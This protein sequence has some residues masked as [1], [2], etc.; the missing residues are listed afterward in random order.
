MAR[1][2]LKDLWRASYKGAPF[3]TE[4]DQESGGRRI[5][6]HQFPMR[7]EPFL[8]DLGEDLREFDITAYLA[9]DSADAE[10][11]ALSAA[12]ASRGA[13]VLVM[14]VQGPVLVRCVSF[15]RDS[16][17]D[18]AGY[19]A[20]SLKCCRE[21]AS[22][23]LATVASLANLIFVAADNAATVVAASFAAEFTVSG[24]SGA[25]PQPVDFVVA[26]AINGLRNGVAALEAIRV[27]EPVDPVASAVQRDALQ[28]LYDT[29]PVLLETPAGITMAPLDLI[30]TTRALG[31]AMPAN[32]A[33]RAFEA[34]IVAG[35]AGA[36]AVAASYPTSNLR[37][38][39]V[40]AAATQRALR[41]AALLAYSEA[42]ARMVI[43]DRPAGITLRANVAEY[44]EAEVVDLPASEID[45]VHQ[46]GVLRGAVIDYI[47]RA[48]LDL[49][50][51]ITVE[52]NLSLPSLAL[53]W[54]LYQDP[55]R[56]IELVARNRVVHPS[57][58]PVAFE[59]LAR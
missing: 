43:P 59:A 51:V 27:R 28:S 16:T 58:M 10:A 47:S 9:S 20:F 23:A 5:V 21:G 56:S 52:T 42:I 2:W 44:F 7:D 39:A 54:R 13:G 40:N 25:A 49:A 33:A 57:F 38:A 15:S 24:Q 53:A 12:C 45:L 50:P 1:D 31:D 8:E 29:M 22:S 55:Q 48:I 4:R 34:I 37:A 3:W 14:P 18:R 32:T 11:A 41:L 19:L 36:T 46:I 17:K 26:T 6:K 35:Q 30:A